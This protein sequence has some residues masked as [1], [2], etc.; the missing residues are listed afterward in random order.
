M[1]NGL[2]VGMVTLDLVYLSAKL[3]GNNQKVVASDYTVSAGGPATNAAVTFSYLG[4]RATLVGAIGTHPIT[5]LIRSD[6][7]RHGVTIADLDP[8]ATEPPPVSSIIV[9]EATG[10][11]AVISI[12]ATKI[13]ASIQQ[14]P[15]AIESDID[16]VLIDGHQM[17]VS[18]AIA[19]LAKHQAIPVVIDG[20]S[21]KPGFET[22]LPFVDYAIC[23][24]NFYPPGCSK[25]EEVMAYLAAV[26]IPHIA[27]TQ[28]EKPI[29][30]FNLGVS[31]Q[32]QVA[33]NNAVDTLGAGDIFHG[34]FCHYILRQNFIDTLAAAAK[35]AS[36]S[37]QFFGTRQWMQP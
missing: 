13:Q 21:W 16:V 25:S 31:G 24:A 37:C 8:V 15:T 9:T 19:Q 26:G 27:I 3:P 22:V 5:H 4:D 20:G 11:R 28:G 7:E 32:I 12:N 34:A 36:Y 35:I 2:F 33:Q 14:I 6:L 23:S 18:C 17:A 1:S 10:D 29:Q 30:Y